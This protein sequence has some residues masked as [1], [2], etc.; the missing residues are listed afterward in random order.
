MFID[1]TKYLLKNN[2]MQLQKNMLKGREEYTMCGSHEHQ[3]PL[4][5]SRSAL[6]GHNSKWCVIKSKGSS[7]LV[8]PWQK[9]NTWKW[10]KGKK[11]MIKRKIQNVL[12]YSVSECIHPHFKCYRHHCESEQLVHILHAS[13]QYCISVIFMI[14]LLQ[15][16]FKAS[17]WD[18]ELMSHSQPGCNINI[19]HVP[20]RAGSDK[21]SLCQRLG[22][23][24]SVRNKPRV[25][26]AS[27]ERRRRESPP[28]AKDERSESFAGGARGFAK[29]LFIMRALTHK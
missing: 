22:C 1:T 24:W 17:R 20:E 15:S 19:L 2:L 3:N 26:S 18:D 5:S 4:L 12:K 23:T 16:Q 25:R 14:A 11:S 8:L 10:K 21:R 7:C 13:S 28:E 29:Q 9:N 27:I 6:D